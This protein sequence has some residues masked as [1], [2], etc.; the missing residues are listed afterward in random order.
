MCSNRPIMT[1]SV[2]KRAL[3]RLVMAQLLM[4]VG[5]ILGMAHAATPAHYPGS[6]AGTIDAARKEGKLVVYA[7]TDIGAAVHL[8]KDF[9]ALYPAIRVEYNEI[10]SNELYKRYTGELRERMPSADLIWGPAMDLMIKLVN[11]GYALNYRSPESAKIPTWATWRDEAYGTTYEPIVLVY[12]KRMLS[13]SD[14]PDSRA[15]LE[16]LFRSQPQRFNGKVVTYDAERYGIGFLLATQDNKSMHGSWDLMA[17]M[18]SVN[19]RQ[20]ASTSQML[21]RI[22]T[23]EFLIGYNLLGSYVAMRA[24]NDPNLGYLLPKDYTLVVSRIAFI[25]QSARNTNAAK[26][27]LDYLLSQRG[28]SVMAERAHLYA[29]RDDI[30][31]EYTAAALG[32][33]YANSI[34]PIHLGQGLLFHLDQSRRAKFLD[35]WRQVTRPQ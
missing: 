14:V 24:K 25:S 26:L 27:F 33:R 17:S 5:P 7:A 29:I 35:K 15:G 10:R 34:K 28:Q 6:Y 19:L 31:G 18:G 13:A 30:E 9:E 8:L 4:V 12:N 1:L 21:E 23:G 22:A 2:E 3:W 16:R 32:R 11:D 20:V